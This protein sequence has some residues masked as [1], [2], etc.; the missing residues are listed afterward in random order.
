MRAEY[1]FSKGLRGKYAKQFRE[2]TN[3]VVLSPDVSEAFPNSE[4]VNEALRGL[5][6]LSEKVA[7]SQKQISHNKRL[8]QTRRGSTNGKTKRRKARR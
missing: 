4:L 6:N 8:Q 2:G 3:V 1:D 5:L 7:K